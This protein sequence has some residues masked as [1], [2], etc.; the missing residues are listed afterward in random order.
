MAQVT[1]A[2]RDRLWRAYVVALV[3]VI[4]ER[5]NTPWLLRW[6]REKTEPAYNAAM[7]ALLDAGA[8]PKLFE[9]EPAE[10]KP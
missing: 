4:V 6:R 1:D 9:I 7:R 8:D 3:R 5:A 10:L 2:E